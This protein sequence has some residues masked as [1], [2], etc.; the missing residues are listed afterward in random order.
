M[1]TKPLIP[2]FTAESAVKKVRMAEDAWNTR[3][4]DQWD[5]AR[6][7]IM[8]KGRCHG[9]DAE[10]GLARGIAFAEAAFLAPPLPFPQQ[11]A[12]QHR[13]RRRRPSK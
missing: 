1:E 2:P 6:L 9:D 8:S 4:P 13:T 5:T 10:E 11:A 7:G 3:E 12:P